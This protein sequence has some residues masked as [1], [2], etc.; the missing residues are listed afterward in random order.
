MSF[1]VV[2]VWAALGIDGDDDECMMAADTGAGQFVPLVA[3]DESRLESM[4]SFVKTVLVK[5]LGAPVKIVEFSVRTDL[6]TIEP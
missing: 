3:A 5:Q 6:E 1:R 4:R 2:K